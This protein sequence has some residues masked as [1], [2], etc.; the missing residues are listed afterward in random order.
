MYP[1][2]QK[3]LCDYDPRFIM[4][5]GLMFDDIIMNIIRNNKLEQ[6]IEEN[7]CLFTNIE[8]HHLY[9][10]GVTSRNLPKKGNL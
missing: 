8:K 9:V 1:L 3:D 6:P 7:D 2:N 10:Q 5:S 4:S